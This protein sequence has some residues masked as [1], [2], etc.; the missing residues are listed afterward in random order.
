MGPVTV[1]GC[2][3]LCPTYGRD[4]YACY[5][6]AENTNPESLTAGF[7]ELGLSDKAIRRRFLSINNNAPAFARAAQEIDSQME[8]GPGQDGGHGHG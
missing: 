8:I 7:R 4:C 3:V 2:G 5:G 1:T 6:P